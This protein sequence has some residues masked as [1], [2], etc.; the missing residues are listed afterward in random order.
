MVSHRLMPD[1]YD[2]FVNDVNDLLNGR[3]P[4]VA[5]VLMCWSLIVSCRDRD[6]EINA[7][8]PVR[9]PLDR[10]IDFANENDR[11]AIG[12]QSAQG[13]QHSTNQVTMNGGPVIP[14]SR[15]CDP[16]RFASGGP[17]W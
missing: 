6:Y 9:A 3:G 7:L 2:A 17:Y 15:Q 14:E 11:V 12:L 4:R 16:G 10:A 13:V 5:G 1:A 8:T